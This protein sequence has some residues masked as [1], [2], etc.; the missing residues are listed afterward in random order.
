MLTRRGLV[1]SLAAVIAAPAIVRPSSLMPVKFMDPYYTRFIQYYDERYD[2]AAIRVDR[3]TFPLPMPQYAFAPSEDL[4]RR[5]VPK[6]F[7]ESM[8]PVDGQI[9]GANIYF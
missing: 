2:A 3:A 7:V 1:A 6:R 4:I 9:I 8:R 5:F